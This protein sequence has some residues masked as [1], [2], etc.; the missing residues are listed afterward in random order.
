LDSYIP[1]ERLA[2]IADSATAVKTDADGK[3]TLPPVPPG[4]YYLFGI[5][6]YA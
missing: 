6:Q 2:F 3:A 5:G 4:V 1:D